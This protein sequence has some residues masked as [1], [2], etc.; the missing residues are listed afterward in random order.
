MSR[1]MDLILASDPFVLSHIDLVMMIFIFQDLFSILNQL[2][3]NEDLIPQL[4]LLLGG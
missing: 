3:L 2:F 1:M 4:H